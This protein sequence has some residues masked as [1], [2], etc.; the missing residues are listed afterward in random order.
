MVNRVEYWYDAKVCR[1]EVGDTTGWKPAL[2]LNKS[3]AA[4]QHS[5]T[6]RDEEKLLA[7]FAGNVNLFAN[8]ADE[9]WPPPSEPKQD[10]F[11]RETASPQVGVTPNKL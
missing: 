8:A 2:L 1:L 9:K 7:A 6:L 10:R 5:T 11:A 3:C 4:A